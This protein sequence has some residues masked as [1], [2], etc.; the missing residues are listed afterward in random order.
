METLEQKLLHIKETDDKALRNQVI[1]DY[2]PFI[3]SEISKKLGRYVRSETDEAFIVGMLA[4]DEAITR[5]EEGRGKFLSFASLVI[6][7]RIL[8]YIKKNKSYNNTV[9]LDETIIDNVVDNS[10]DEHLKD[11]MT[12]F[13]EML[14]KFKID[15]ETLADTSPK[16]EDTRKETTK[17]GI[18]F[19]QDQPV[20]EFLYSKFRLPITKVVKRYRCS[21]K[22]VERFKQYIIAVMVIMIEEL[23]TMKN[24]LVGKGQSLE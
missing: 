19:S 4:F 20:V 2:Q 10:V 13:V 6:S 12:I 17:L 21:K 7:S 11:D 22:T 1:T 3:L 9:V 16:H 8:D 24:F 5:Y 23:D 18:T 15:V 14:A